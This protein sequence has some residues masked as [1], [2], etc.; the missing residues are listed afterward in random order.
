MARHEGGCLCG[1]VRFVADVDPM[2]VTVCHCRFC[3]RTTGSA[4][5]VQPVFAKAD[6]HV[7]A[8]TPKT[9]DVI[10]EGSGKRISIHFCGTCGAR[11]ML[12]VERLPT[13]VG[14]FAGSFDE[15]GK[16]G[17]SSNVR[18]VFTGT[19]QDGTVLPADVPLFH[20]HAI[21][22]DGSLNEPKVLTEPARA[23]R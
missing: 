1:E 7:T 22:L 18:H 23:N 21:Q 4:Y 20:D 16:L 2:R 13:G 8:G 9:Y 5:M 17:L 11:V 15:P 10:S 3:Q 6:F 19:A 12:G 14:A